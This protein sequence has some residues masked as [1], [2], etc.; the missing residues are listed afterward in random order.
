MASFLGMELS[1]VHVRDIVNPQKNFPKAVLLACLFIFATMTLGSLS[2]AAVVPAG[3][4]NLISG[5]MQVYSSIFERFGLQFLTPIVTLLIVIGTTG[6]MINWLIS[7]AKGLL[8]AAEF[9][10]LPAIFQKQNRHGV[11]SNILFAQ[12]GLVSLFCLLF[13]LE[14]SIN[15]YYWFLTALSTELYMIMYVLM[16]CTAIRLHYLCNE[17]PGAFKIPGGSWGIWVASL[18]GLLGCAATIT[19]SFFPPEHV[20]IGNPWRYCAMIAIGNLATIAPLG[21][22]FIYERLRPPQLQPNAQSSGI[23]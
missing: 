12:A 20:D 2:I 17:R 6:T 15:S 8:H 23:F 10:F 9:G 3:E 14:G 1:G 11:A 18:L 16:F 4:I 7:P 13:L 22:F 21:L 19:V 5:V